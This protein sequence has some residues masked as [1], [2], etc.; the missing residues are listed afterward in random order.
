MI[1]GWIPIESG[2]KKCH[3]LYCPLPQIITTNGNFD[4]SGRGRWYVTKILT[5]SDQL[6][7]K[8]KSLLVS[9]GG[10]PSTPTY[11]PT[12]NPT[13]TT[14]DSDHDCDKNGIK[15][16]WR[17]FSFSY[18]PP[19]LTEDID[20]V[21]RNFLACNSDWLVSHHYS[22]W[23]WTQWQG[24]PLVEAGECR[25][26]Y[27]V[28]FIFVVTGSPCV[29]AWVDILTTLSIHKPPC[30]PT[31]PFTPEYTAM[32]A[33]SNFINYISNDSDITSNYST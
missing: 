14:H 13:D 28:L 19:K 32:V 18:Q 30:L 9:H 5:R 10:I 23:S 7:A 21:M 6:K 15:S 22:G 11:P 8:T 17:H 16:A 26:I 24:R 29:P 33:V 31:S 27:F 3:K 12:K 25:A 4:F 20:L 1:K 2:R